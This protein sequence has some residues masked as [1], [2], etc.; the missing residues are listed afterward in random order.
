MKNILKMDE[1]I[2][3]AF[4][5]TLEKNGCVWSCTNKLRKHTASTTTSSK[6][7]VTLG[8][9]KLFQVNQINVPNWRTV[10]KFSS[11]VPNLKVLL[12]CF[13]SA[14]GSRLLEGVLGH[15][16]TRKICL[17][18]RCLE[19]PVSVFSGQYLGLKNN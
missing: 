2:L 14:E 13:L 17:K 4:A 10:N 9:I 19:I 16:P 15:C 8:G 3:K 5:M 7:R 11:H 6:G 18:F 1:K 12:F